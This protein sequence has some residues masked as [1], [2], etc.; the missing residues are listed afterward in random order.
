MHILELFVY[1]HLAI[2]LGI[3]EYLAIHQGTYI[4]SYLAK[5]LAIYHYIYPFS[6]YPASY[7]SD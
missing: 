4:P 7:L 6:I 2:Y 3:Y 1:H 5:F